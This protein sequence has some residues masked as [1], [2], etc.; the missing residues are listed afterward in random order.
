MGITKLDFRIR[1]QEKKE[2]KKKLFVLENYII[3]HKGPTIVHS[4]LL[5]SWIIS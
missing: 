2:M 1:L 5:S 4:R 3:I